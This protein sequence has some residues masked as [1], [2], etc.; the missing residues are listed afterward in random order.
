[1]AKRVVTRIYTP[2][3][4]NQQ[5]VSDDLN[6]FGFDALKLWNVSRWT[7]SRVWDEIDYIPE[8]DELTAYF[9]SHE[10]YADLHSQSSQPVLQELAE[11]FNG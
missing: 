8:H 9:K 7:I 2:S 3:I 5:Q 10:C 4:S 1:M 11:A 6:S